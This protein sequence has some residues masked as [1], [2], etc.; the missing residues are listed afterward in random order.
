M[1]CVGQFDQAGLPLTT[2]RVWSQHATVAFQALSLIPLLTQLM[3]DD[4]AL[5]GMTIDHENGVKI[6]L[7]RSPE[8][9]VAFL[10]SGTGPDLTV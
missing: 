4:E 9:F 8:G 6:R 10:D 3:H 1:V 2:A 5:Q 7:T